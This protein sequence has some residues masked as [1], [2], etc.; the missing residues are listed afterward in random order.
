MSQIQA[1]RAKVILPWPSFGE[2]D[3][4]F[5]HILVMRMWNIIFALYSVSAGGRA[6]SYASNQ[7]SSPEE[8]WQAFFANPVDWWDNRKNKVSVL[9]I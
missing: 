2:D 9:C 5:A 1:L 8:L 4:Q 3:E 7:G 6:G